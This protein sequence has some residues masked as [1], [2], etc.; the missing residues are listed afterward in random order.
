MTVP[1]Q[2]GDTRPFWVDV[3]QHSSGI[4]RGRP[5]GSVRIMPG[6]FRSPGGRIRGLPVREEFLVWKILP[7]RKVLPARL[8][9]GLGHNSFSGGL[10]CK[11]LVYY[12]FNI[13]ES[14]VEGTTFSGG[15]PTYV[16]NHLVGVL[17]V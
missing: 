13:R 12:Y 16:S 3:Y 9:T 6:G 5:A 8:R 14:Y 10:T 1:L 4:A 2:S 11:L 17:T 15:L 7:T